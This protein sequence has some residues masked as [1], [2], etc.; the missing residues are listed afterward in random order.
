VIFETYSAD[1]HIFVADDSMNQLA[2]GWE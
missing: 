1:D 2:Q